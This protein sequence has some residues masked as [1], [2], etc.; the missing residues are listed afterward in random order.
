MALSGWSTAN[1]IRLASGLIT[2]V[3]L[4]MAGWFYPTSAANGTIMGC[5]TSGSAF[6]RN[7]FRLGVDTSPSVIALTSDGASVG[8]AT[9]TASATL[10][11]WNHA[12]GVFTGIASRD[13]YLNGGNK[14]S[15]TTSLTPSGID[16]TSIGIGDGST[17]ST[18]FHNTGMLAELGWWNVALD[19]AEIA[20][21]AAGVP[22]PLVRPQ[23]LMAYV[24]IV[25]DLVAWKG[26]AFA[27]T[28]SLTVADHCRIYGV[29]A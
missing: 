19:A 14:G 18:P 22:P 4:T 1:Y 11:A 21:L 7:S 20:A 15:N 26:G 27:I 3:P 2:A 29:A 12:A 8:N 9:T 6:N 25:R 10:N 13:S 28:G 5:F 23:S 16:R 24:P 17:A